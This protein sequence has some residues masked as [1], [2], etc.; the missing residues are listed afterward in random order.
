MY[1]E[2]TREYEYHV[3]HYGHRRKWVSRILFPCGRR[4]TGTPDKLVAFYK[5]K[6]CP[7]LFALG[8]HH[9][10]MDLWDRSIN[11]GIQWIWGRRRYSGRMGESGKKIRIVFWSQLACRPCV[12][13]VWA[14]SASWHE[15]SEERNSIR[16]KN[17]PRQTE[18]ENGGKDTTHR[19][20]M[21]R[22]IHWVRT[23]GTT[24][25]FTASGHGAMGLCTE[26]GIL[27][28]LL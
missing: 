7:V 18:K 1:M 14:F 13:L 20:C 28:K 15:R 3:K 8:N 21:H 4:K 24:E 23:A 27:Y 2:G 6:R 11:P 17:W 25:W 26:P 10:N 16:W 22:T 12:E 9:D 5:K 19:I